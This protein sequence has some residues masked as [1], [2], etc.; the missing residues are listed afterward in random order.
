MSF[1]S[2]VMKAFC[3]LFVV[4]VVA[5]ALPATPAV[6]QSAAA[7]PPDARPPVTLAG[8]R[9]SGP[10]QSDS[11]C[12]PFALAA[13]GGVAGAAISA[14][15]LSASLYALSVAQNCEARGVECEGITLAWISGIVPVTIAGTALGFGGGL[16]FGFWKSEPPS[17]E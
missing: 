16:A 1:Y 12:F 10:C 13:M 15:G 2:L 8:F 7:P 6:A 17:T 11:P 4:C 3:C 9:D 14:V 5:V